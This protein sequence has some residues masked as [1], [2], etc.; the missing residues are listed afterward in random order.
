MGETRP[1][2]EGH[3]PVEKRSDQLPGVRL[4]VPSLPEPGRGETA[5]VPGVE[6]EDCAGPPKPGETGLDGRRGLAGAGPPPEPLEGRPD[7]PVPDG[8]KPDPGPGRP[9]PMPFQ[10]F[11]PPE[12]FQG[13]S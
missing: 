7:E 4:P 9:E 11:S 1:Q 6:D 5:S 10:G 8:R 3:G 13:F 2:P 12:A